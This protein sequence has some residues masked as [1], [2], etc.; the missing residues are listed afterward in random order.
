MKKSSCFF[1]SLLL[2][3]AI[4]NAAFSQPVK[5]DLFLSISYYNNNNQTQYLVAHAKSKINGKF[6]MIPGISLGFYIGSEAP[7]NLIGKGITNEKGEAM[8]FITP[9]AKDEWNRLAGI[10]FIVV[11]Q[12]SKTFDAATGNRDLSKAKLRIDT[13]PDKKITATLL[14][15]KDS[16]WV[17]VKATD[18]RIAIK[19]LGGDVNVA[20]TPVYTTDSLGVASADCKR[21]SMPGDSKGNLV[22]VA[23]LD[24]HDLYGNLSAEKTVPW[25]VVHRYVSQFDKRTLFARRGRSPVW[26]ELMAYSIIVVVWGIILY[27]FT[28]IRKLKQ[29]GT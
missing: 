16:V 20:E 23:R 21:D 17:P 19:R 18:V 9:S 28:Q 6:Q 8:V 11:S 29:M 7:A 13:F 27:L 1:S 22:L 24:D 12:A 14:A 10:R 5:N 2:L 26:L 15:L 25:G 4:S 3:L